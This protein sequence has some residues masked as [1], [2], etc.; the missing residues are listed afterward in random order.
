MAKTIYVDGWFCLLDFQLWEGATSS[1][2]TVTYLA[3]LWMHLGGKNDLLQNTEFTLTFILSFLW[4]LF[5]NPHPVLWES[6]TGMTSIILPF[7]LKCKCE[8]HRVCGMMLFPSL[9]QKAQA[10]GCHSCANIGDSFVGNNTL[11]CLRPPALVRIA[12]C[13]VGAS[14]WKM[15][16]ACSSI[17]FKNVRNVVQISLLPLL[18][19]KF[20][21]YQGV[22]LFMLK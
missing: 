15:A 4:K 11:H 9:W 16:N 18:M 2:L 8:G 22:V 6:R 3:N 21:V 12:G 13:G 7:L 1:K 19:Y 17:Y 10:C 20:F 5:S 14:F